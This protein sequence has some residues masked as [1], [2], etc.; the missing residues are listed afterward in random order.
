MINLTAT[1]LIWVTVLFSGIKNEGVASYYHDSLHGSVTAS[2]EVYNI[3]ELSC[4]HKDLPFGTVL[5]VVNLQNNKSVMVR[6][7]DRGPFIDGRDIDLSKHAAK[8]LDMLD[9]GV[10]KVRYTIMYLYG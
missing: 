4:A 3:N 1:F 6:V 2:G 7:N 8:E 10:I 9:D 5:L